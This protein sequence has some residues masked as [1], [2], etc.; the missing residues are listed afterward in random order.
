MIDWTA[1]KRGTPRCDAPAIEVV[2]LSVARCPNKLGRY[3]KLGSSLLVASI[4]SGAICPAI[5]GFISD[6]S[7]IRVAFIVPLVCQA[8]VLYFALRGYRPVLV[9]GS[10]TAELSTLK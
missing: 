4:L 5:M 8:Y 2:P 9:A 1:Q 6:H 7:N 3:T 10:Q